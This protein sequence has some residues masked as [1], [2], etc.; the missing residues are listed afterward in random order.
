MRALTALGVLPYLDE[1]YSKRE[2]PVSV[3]TLVKWSSFNSKTIDVHDLTHLSDT[4]LSI[5]RCV[6]TNGSIVNGRASKFFC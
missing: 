5:S 6:Y 2:I 1:N 3:T 4:N